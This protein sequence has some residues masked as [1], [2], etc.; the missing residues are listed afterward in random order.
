MTGKDPVI[1]T[2]PRLEE[3]GAWC[4]RLADG[5]LTATDQAEFEDWL[6]ADPQNRVAFE[7]AVG[8]WRGVEDRGL[9]PDAIALR[10]EAL[11]LYEGANRGRWGLKPSGPRVRIAAMAAGLILALGVSGLWA[12]MRPVVYTT[13]VG[14]RR[15]VVLK[16]GSK[17]SMD[18]AT[19]VSVRYSGDARRLVLDHGRAK[20]DVAKDAN[21]PF[22]VAAA[23]KVVRATGT[24]FSVEMLQHRVRVVLYEGRVA[25]LGTS[26]GDDRQK[27]LTL[28]VALTPGRE[29]VTTPDDPTAQV[30]A[31]DPGRSLAWEAGQLVFVDEPL[32]SAVERMNRYS[33][34]KL[35]V[36]DAAAGRVRIDGVFAADQTDAFVSGVTGLFPLRAVETA[37]G[38]V[39][40]SRQ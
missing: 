30:A 9:S 35:I 37:E 21:R 11:A 14:E 32:A 17:M 22:T 3:A 1:Q 28:K 39:L 4:V 40:V 20:F 18:A 24:Q 10:R 6:A 5:T 36:G 23:D 33:N 34:D 7:D 2:D 12:A 26:R 31:T 38:R 13:A 27:P 15:V 25:V 8:I 16:D 19:E 29:L